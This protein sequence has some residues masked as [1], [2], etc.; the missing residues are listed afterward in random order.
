VSFLSLMFPTWRFK[1]LKNVIERLQIMKLIVFSLTI[2]IKLFR[3][4]YFFLKSRHITDILVV[5]CKELTVRTKT[6]EGV[7][8][9]A[10]WDVHTDAR[11]AAG[12]GVAAIALLTVRTHVARTTLALVTI[13]YRMYTSQIKLYQNPSEVWKNETALWSR[14]DWKWGKSPS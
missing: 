4:I 14:E 3:E 7:A 6:L 9:V 8:L 12:A 2:L 5:W 13:L 1:G 11:V 10:L